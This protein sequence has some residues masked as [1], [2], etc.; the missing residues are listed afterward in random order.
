MVNKSPL[1]RGLKVNRKKALISSIAIVAFLLISSISYLLLTDRDVYKYYSGLGSGIAISEDDQLIAFSYFNNGKSAIYTAGQDGRDVKRISNPEQVYHMKPQFS[2]DG[3]K[4]LYLSQNKN[5]IQSLY[6][7]NVDGT[8][9]KKLSDELQ[10][11]SGAVFADDNETIYF[12]SMPAEEFQKSEGETQEGYD[13]FSVKIDG[14]D[15]K[16][17]TDRDFSTMDSLVYSADKKEILFKDFDDI[18][19]FDLEDKRVY[20]ADFNGEMPADFYHL[21]LSAKRNAVAYTA[22]TEESKD[23]SL[24]EYDLFLKDL[25][26]GETERL[27]DMNSSLVSPVFFNEKNNILFLESINW[28]QEPEEYKLRTV[29]LKTKKLNE[30]TL[31]MPELKGS[32]LVLKAIDDS[33]NGSTVGLLYT[34]LLILIT[35]YLWPERVFLPSIIS[36]VIGLLTLAASFV[37]AAT[38]DPWAGIGVGMLAAGLLACTLVLFTFAFVMKLIRKGAK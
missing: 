16:Q 32:N 9:P 5:P 14:T 23:T 30:V 13:L 24:F 10:H 2:P 33:V 3:S 12:A 25:Q 8:N 22:I 6:I 31:D 34:M 17:M 29:D 38:V 35:V 11:I 36:L 28:P 18:N 27:T 4:I 26:N 15:M 19:A 1:L 37:V 7:A 20:M 21:T